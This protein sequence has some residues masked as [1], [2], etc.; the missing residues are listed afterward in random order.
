MLL[1]SKDSVER[2]QDL[3]PKSKVFEYACDRL[4]RRSTFMRKLFATVV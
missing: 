2:V 1:M 3:D 4:E